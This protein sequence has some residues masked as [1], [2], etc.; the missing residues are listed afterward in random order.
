M[1]RTGRIQSESD[2]YHVTARG[3]GKQVIFEDDR[4]R[5][6][7][8]KTMR[9]RLDECNVEL[10]AWCFMQNH[11]HL[12]LH[13]PLSTMSS[14][15][16]LLLSDYARYYNWRYDR[17]GHLFEKRFDSKPVIDERQLLATIRYIHQNPHDLGVTDF[18][19][20]PWSSYREYGKQKSFTKTDLIEEALGTF[21]E[22]EQFMSIEEEQ[23]EEYEPIRKSN[24]EAHDIVLMV[25]GADGGTVLQKYGKEE[26]N[27]VLRR[28]KKQ[29][30]SIRQIERLTGIG[31]SI[32]QRA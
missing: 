29:G 24:D 4:D 15:M 8:G 11:I 20:Y 31:R 9:D 17:V 12:L 32:I 27:E 18:S 14:F 28:L 2:I 30:L 1:S 7:F 3:V 6:K 26:R 5:R 21:A 10:Y 19:A 16:R 22:F 13:C 23:N 25:L